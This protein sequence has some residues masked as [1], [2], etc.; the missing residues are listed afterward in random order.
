MNI[1]GYRLLEKTELI[2][3]GD[4]CG[5]VKKYPIDMNNWKGEP[6]DRCNQ[7][8]FRPMSQFTDAYNEE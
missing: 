8:V 1:V 7:P 2:Q 3:E 6:A 5:W 4:V